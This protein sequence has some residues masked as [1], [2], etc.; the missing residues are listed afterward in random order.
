MPT[1]FTIGFQR[2]P[3]SEFIHLLQQGGV[4]AV[5][6]IRLRNTSQLSGYAKRDD[7]AFLLRQGFGIAYEHHLEL[8]PTDEILDTFRQ[9]K[10][11]D[12]YVERFGPLLIE[13]QA[14]QVGRDIL[15]RY[16]RVCLLC[17]EPTADQC[18]RR[19][20]AEYWVDHIP[21]LTVSHL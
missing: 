20:V 13:R 14:E 1:I 7:L 17:S 5:I 16:E 6:D 19:L 10:E 18:H 9:D 11:W 15:S 12:S 8:A 21:D 3:L 2:K 4:E